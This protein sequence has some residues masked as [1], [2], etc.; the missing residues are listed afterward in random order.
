M[1]GTTKSFWSSGINPNNDSMLR[2][3]LKRQAK[4]LAS[5]TR[6]IVEADINTALMVDGGDG[7]QNQPHY[8]HCFNIISPALGYQH[9]ALFCVKQNLLAEFPVVFRSD[10]WG[11]QG[12]CKAENFA[13]FNNCLEEILSSE[14]TAELVNSLIAQS[15]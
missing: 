4:E 9:F 6:N 13:D 1:E 3:A 15:A 7:F 8:Q 2:A 14:K 12:W 5:I 10:Y 11:K